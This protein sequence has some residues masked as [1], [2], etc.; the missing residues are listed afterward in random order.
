M[1]HA[2]QDLTFE[3]FMHHDLLGEIKAVLLEEFRSLEQYHCTLSILPPVITR[4]AS[5]E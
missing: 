4:N 3:T 2:P 1:S 5:S